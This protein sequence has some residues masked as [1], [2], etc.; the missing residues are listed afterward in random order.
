MNPKVL[1][2][3]IFESKNK[4]LVNTV[5]CVGIMGK[6]VALEFKKRYPEMYK[7]YKADCDHGRIKVGEPVLYADLLGTSIINFP[8]KKHWKSPSLLKDIEKGLDIFLKQYKELGIES[9]A[10]PPLGCG[11]G[12]LSWDDVG[13]LMYQK[14]SQIDIPVEIFAPFGTNAD[15]LK[16]EFLSSS[17]HNKQKRGATYSNIN[18]AGNLAA[19]EVLARLEQQKYTKPV[20]RTMFQ[21]I[22]YVLTELSV[23]TGLQ[24]TKSSYG[25]FSSNLKQIIHAFANQN[26]IQES[27][28]FNMMRVSVGEEYYSIR[29]DFSKDLAELEPK[30][31]RTVDLFSR[32]KNTDQAEEV[33][34]IL[35]ATKDLAKKDGKVTEDDILKYILEWKNSWDN[36]Y[37]KESISGTIKN[38]EELGWINVVNK[39]NQFE[40]SYL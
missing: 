14:L 2:G 37:K 19:L 32:I 18:S 13:P 1:I 25:P 10:F 39:N 35:F 40:G 30:I 15:K 7:Q 27:Q 8:T 9:V 24:F 5:N 16:P 21:K 17:R 26:L 3:N 31:L 29:K 11:N 20:G 23:N 36:Q 34:T 38:L 22:Y 12:G 4:T 28:Y 6:G 33:T